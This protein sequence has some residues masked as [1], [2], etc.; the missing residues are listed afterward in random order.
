[1][2]SICTPTRDSVHAGFA[3]DL[4]NLT[5]SLDELA[6]VVF[7]VSQGTLL[8]N[9]RTD[10]V[11]QALKFNSTHV[12]FIDS[13][14]RFPINT[15]ESLRLRH[16]DIVGANCI[17]RGTTKP[18]AQNKYGF[19]SS[20]GNTGLEEIDKIGFGVTLINTKVF[21]K[22]PE[23]WFATPYDGE[24]FV[25]EDIFFCHKAQENGFKIYVDH[26]LSQHIK[27]TGVYDYKIE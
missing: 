4:F 18:T 15:L 11:K 17:Q 24:K 19:L 3:F 10:L 2:I 13:D 21:L 26:D 5:N 7:L 14:M 25:G 1:M 22:I 8:C 12:L 23:P 16:V 9:Q 20:K 6:Q 27:H